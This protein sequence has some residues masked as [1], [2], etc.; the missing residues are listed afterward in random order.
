MVGNH[1]IISIE[2]K[3]S[4]LV[5]SSGVW[6]T[7][8]LCEV[9]ITFL[10]S[11]WYGC[12]LKLR[13]AFAED[14]SEW[15]V[16]M[17]RVRE[18]LVFYDTHHV[19]NETF[20]QCTSKA[21]DTNISRPRNHDFESWACGSMCVWDHDTSLVRVIQASHTEHHTPSTDYSLV[22]LCLLAGL[23]DWFCWCRDA[24]VEE[25]VRWV[26]CC[27]IVWACPAADAIAVAWL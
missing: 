12:N 22:L 23:A 11:C 7:C 8:K 16:T 24:V 15:M 19:S 26:R 10:A 3:L 14:T 9:R 13:G 25:P 18:M 21:G 27:G 1:E 2:P 17:I 20:R 6:E 4:S 5:S